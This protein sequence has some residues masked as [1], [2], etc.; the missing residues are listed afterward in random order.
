MKHKKEIRAQKA[1]M[2]ECEKEAKQHEKESKQCKKEAAKQKRLKET[3]ENL[4][5]F[6]HQDEREVELQKT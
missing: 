4:T 3:R 2:K 6:Q 1:A 5:I